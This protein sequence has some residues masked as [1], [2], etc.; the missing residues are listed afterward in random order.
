MQ[1]SVR[2]PA[3]ISIKSFPFAWSSVSEGVFPHFPPSSHANLFR[4]SRV[5]LIPSFAAPSDLD[6]DPN[7]FMHCFARSALGVTCKPKQFHSIS[8][9]ISAVE[10][11]TFNIHSISTQYLRQGLL[12]ARAEVGTAHTSITGFHLNPG[13]HNGL[14]LS[15]VLNSP[16]LQ[17]SLP[18]DWSKAPYSYLSHMQIVSHFSQYVRQTSLVFGIQG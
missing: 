9:E 8:T 12:H 4:V 17:Y 3:D 13:L 6:V 15:R 7:A 14:F 10:E 1:G 11:S 2:K 16:S 18:F 5:H